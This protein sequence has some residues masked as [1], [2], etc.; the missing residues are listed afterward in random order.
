MAG[1]TSLEDTYWR[2]EGEAKVSGGG[3]DSVS[4]VRWQEHCLAT[5][6]LDWKGRGVLAI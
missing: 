3:N 6:F 1:C 5:C 2:E 4:G